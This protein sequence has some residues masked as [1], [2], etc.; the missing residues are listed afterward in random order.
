MAMWHGLAVRAGDDIPAGRR[1]QLEGR[2]LEK[3]AR[4]GKLKKMRI[5]RT[6]EDGRLRVAH[7]SSRSAFSRKFLMGIAPLP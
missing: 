2:D 1:E 3:R 6:S 5:R 4:A 7:G